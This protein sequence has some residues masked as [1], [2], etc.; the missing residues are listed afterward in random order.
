MRRADV[1]DGVKDGQTS[2]EQ[3]ELDQLRRDKRRLGIENEI[4]RRAAAYFAARSL[5]KM[6]CPLVRDLAAEGIPVRLTCGVLGFSTQMYYAWLAA[7]VSARDLQD[8][9][10]TNALLDAHGDDPAFGYR[11]LADEFERAGVTVGERR[12]W[13]LCS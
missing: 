11:F 5:P 3:S 7:P 10:L 2:T 1:D 4:L 8:A 9:Y 12:V 6:T 13:R